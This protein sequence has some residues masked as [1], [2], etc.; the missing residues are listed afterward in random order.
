MVLSTDNFTEYLLGF[1]TLHGDAGD[2]GMIQYLFK[3][4]VYE[5]AN[6]LVSGFKNNG[7]HEKANALQACIAAIPTDG[8]GI[9]NSDLDQIQATSYQEV[10]SI[11]NAYQDGDTSLK[12]HPVIQR[13]LNSYYKRENPYNLARKT[14]LEGV[15]DKLL[16]NH[17]IDRWKHEM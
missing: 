10:D 9:T 13:Y 4:E 7:E 8:L 1:W 15:D 12:S 2:Y 6:Y 16:L 11:L 3:T 17:F 5:L 14:L